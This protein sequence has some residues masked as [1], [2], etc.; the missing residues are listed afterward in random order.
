M[1]DPVGDLL[2]FDPAANNPAGALF[3]GGILHCAERLSLDKSWK[4]LPPL[5][6]CVRIA[7]H[8]VRWAMAMDAV[9]RV[10]ICEHPQ[11]YRAAKSK[12]DPND[13][14]LLATINGALGGILSYAAAG[15]DQG[16][17][18]LSPTPAEW[19]GQLPKVTTGDGWKSPRGERI[20]G[21][22]SVAER[23]VCDGTHDA[24]DATGLGLFA[25]GRLD[26]VRVFPGAV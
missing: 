14:I 19:I 16:V 8:A 20:R 18:M 23:A 9:P 2:A 7:A 24:I 26:R 13:L 4:E 21:K 10:L 17:V 3:R 6:R 15:R 12:G 5:D 22:L 1:I 25:L 11:I